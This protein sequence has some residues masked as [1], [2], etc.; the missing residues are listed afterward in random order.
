LTWLQSP[1]PA[2]SQWNLDNQNNT[3][4]CRSEGDESR[5][6][7]SRIAGE[8]W[9]PFPLLHLAIREWPTCDIFI[10]DFFSGLIF[11]PFSS[12]N[13]SRDVV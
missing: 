11:S 6:T 5:W 7:K 4:I 9:T 10:P 13:K 3:R 2:I 12:Q 1:G 8:K